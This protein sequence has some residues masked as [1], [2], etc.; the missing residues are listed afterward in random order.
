VLQRLH[1]WNW[2]L[3]PSLML[4]QRTLA[5]LWA[6][7]A[8]GFKQNHNVLHSQWCQFLYSSYSCRHAPCSGLFKGILLAQDCSGLFKG[9]LLAQDCSGLF[10][11]I[12]LA[13]DCSRLFKGILLAQDCSGLFKGYSTSPG[14]FTIV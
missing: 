9:I 12:L 2:F 1:S 7:K 5:K 13:Q 6:S 8:F 11:G 14:L 3:H 10:K 4:I